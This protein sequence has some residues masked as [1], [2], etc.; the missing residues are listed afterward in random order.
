MPRAT[1]RKQ[2]SA[3]NCETAADFYGQFNDRWLRETRMPPTETRIT[4]AYAIRTRVN[5]EVDAIVRSEGARKGS[6]VADFMAAWRAAE[7][8]PILPGLSP[9]LQT[10]LATEGSADIAARIGWLNRH[11]ISAPIALYV[12]GDPR[13]HDRCRVFIE[14]G[15]PNI[16]IPEYW[17]WTTYRSHRKAYATYVRRLAAAVGLPALLKGYGAEREFAHVYPSALERRARLDMLTWSE[18]C[19]RYPHIDWAAM[20]DAWGLSAADRER[21]TYNITSHPFLHHLQARIQRWPAARWGAWFALLVTQWI[22]GCSPHGPLRAAWFAFSRAYL[23]GMTEDDDAAE[24]RMAIVR[25]MMPN[26]IGKLWVRECCS[27]TLQR[28]VGAMVERVR[29]AAIATIGRTS[30][31][32]PSTRAAAQRKLRA[33]TIEVGWPDRKA[34]RTLELTC[35]FQPDNL[36]GN[37]LALGAAGTD[38]NLGLLRTGCRSPTGANWGRPVYEVNAFYYPDENRFLLPAAIL[39]PPFYD[40]SKSL[41]WNYGGIGATIG[42][43]LCHAFDSD[44]RSYDEHGDKRDWWT[45]NDDREYRSRAAAVVRLYES[46][47]YRGMKVDGSLTLVENIADLGGLE[48]ALA[49]LRS[50][51]GRAAT[52]AEL[53]EFFESYAISWRSKDRRKRAAELLATDFHAPPELRVNHAVRQMDEWYAAYDIPEDCPDYIPPAKRIHFFA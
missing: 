39:R 30:W 33:M 7:A 46:R 45:D 38:H 37:L 15:Q 49:G 1:R 51:L 21:V 10:M 22:A 40:P 53:Q 14:E 3:G 32:A 31:M 29:A 9:L 35:A 44:G 12:Q 41:A 48:F 19:T 18:L 17:G 27:P 34:W 11:G 24:L 42:H 16:G 4:Q 8:H 50:A 20:M 23:Q 5:R 25:A 2:R 13:N 43:E 36:L 47:L 52:K 26:T 28:S 6:P